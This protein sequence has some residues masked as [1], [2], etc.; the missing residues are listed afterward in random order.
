MSE[1]LYL[2][3]DHA[4]ALTKREWFAGQMLAGIGP[5]EA[6]NIRDDVLVDMARQIFR[7]ADAMIAASREPGK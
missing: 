6:Q 1:P 5:F 3:T 7:I 2:T 4:Q